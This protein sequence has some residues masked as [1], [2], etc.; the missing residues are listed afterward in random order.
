MIGCC[1]DL[2]AGTI[3]YTKNGRDLGVAYSGIKKDDVYFPALLLKNCKVTV[4]LKEPFQFPPSGYA[5]ISD[6]TPTPHPNAP[7]SLLALILEPTRELATQTWGNPPFLIHSYDCLTRFKTYMTKPELRIALVVGGERVD[8]RK[9][10]LELQRAHIVVATTSR[11]LPCIP[12][13]G[14]FFDAMTRHRLSLDN[15]LFLILD[16]ADK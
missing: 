7:R 9:Q 2:A 12:Q 8:Y 3:S 15:L 10:A 13:I 14:R 4:S 5:A 6:E 11:V 1:L 16:E